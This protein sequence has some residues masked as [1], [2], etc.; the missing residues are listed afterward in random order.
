MRQLS[1]SA[2]LGRILALFLI[3]NKIHMKK[4]ATTLS[5]L[6]I[7]LSLAS[8]TDVQAQN[9]CSI[10]A[11]NLDNEY[12]YIDSVSFAGI[13]KKSGMGASSY[14]NFTA[15]TPGVVT[16]GQPSPYSITIESDYDEFVTVFIDW[17][18]N[19]VLDDAGEVYAIVSG[20]NA[21]G[22]MTFTG[23]VTPPAGALTGNT[24]MRVI[25][26]W[27][28]ENDG[29]PCLLYTSTEESYGEVE[30]YTITVQSATTPPSV[31]S[32]AVTTTGGATSAI[33]TNGG[34]LPMLATVLP[35][36]ANQNVTWSIVP[37]TGDATI[38]T[39]GLVT[40]TA[41]GTVWAKAVSVQDAT[42]KDSL[43]I[44]IT[45]QIVPI[46]G[47]TVSTQGSVPSQININA[48]TLQMNASIL[49]ATANQNVTWSIVPG[50]GNASISNSGVVTASANGTVW[51]KAV[52]TQ[53][54]S[55]TD[56]LQI[57]ITNQ[58]VGVK[59][60]FAN[61]NIDVYPVPFE[62]NLILDFKSTDI[63]GLHYRLSNVM[64]QII[65]QNG[66]SKSIFNINTSKLPSGLYVISLIEKTGQIST[67]QVVK[68]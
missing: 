54:N 60:L 57:T 10:P 20:T 31:T 37:V 47:I 38:S 46:T 23:N 4:I 14:E 32:V 6:I 22:L 24:R 36:A 9:Y 64:G 53:D 2:Y 30:D 50:T 35:A 51:A 43:Q 44:T 67:I 68:K 58:G 55:F 29:D 66:V 62:N 25:I 52:S 34:T 28:N 26:D 61:N 19:G 3:L 7:V 40:A 39:S 13:Q 27:F 41:N 33:T 15:L 56:S 16:I 12:D 59:G 42:K 17:N 11:A 45:N 5:S 49:P 21:S 63:Q 1:I 8:V 18:Q 65:E 48:G